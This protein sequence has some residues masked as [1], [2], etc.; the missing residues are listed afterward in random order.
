MVILDQVTG[1]LGGG[2]GGGIQGALLQQ[3]VSYLSRPGALNALTQSFQQN[4]LGNVMQSWIGTSQNLPISTDQVRRVLGDNT[5]SEMATKA[6]MAEPEA[7]EGLASLLP[8]V[9]DK[10]S[11]DGREPSSNQLDGLLSGV[12][13]AFS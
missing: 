7:A 4:G 8:Q 3:L 11:P 12:G 1:A 5:V 13:K 9:I 2:K 10:V 6:G